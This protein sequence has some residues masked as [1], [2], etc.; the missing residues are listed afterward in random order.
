MGHSHLEPRVSKLKFLFAR[1]LLTWS[2]GTYPE[3]TLATEPERKPSPSSEMFGLTD[4]MLDLAQAAANGNT[5][6]TSIPNTEH[7]LARQLE[8]ERA[9]HETTQAKLKELH[10]TVSEAFVVNLKAAGMIFFFFLT[11]FSPFFL[12]SGI[13]TEYENKRDREKKWVC[14]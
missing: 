11:S 2:F 7:E 14:K 9:A 1:Q 3:L 5:G 6:S 13:D 10:R 4:S 8:A 12:N